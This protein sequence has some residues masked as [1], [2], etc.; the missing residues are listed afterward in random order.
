M[1]KKKYGSLAL[2][3]AV[4]VGAASFK[5]ASPI[6]SK[7][8]ASLD[9][10]IVLKQGNNIS[11]YAGYQRYEGYTFNFDNALTIEKST[12][13]IVL[14]FENNNN[15]QKTALAFY[16]NNVLNDGT[17]TEPSTTYLYN[18]NILTGTIEHKSYSVGYYSGNGV[19]QK[20][21]RVV[22]PVSNFSKITTDE[23]TATSFTIAIRLK[24]IDT[25]FSNPDI[26]LRSIYLIDNYTKN[27]ELKVQNLKKVY[28]PSSSNFEAFDSGNTGITAN[29]IT[30]SYSEESFVDVQVNTAHGDIVYNNVLPG[31]ELVI[32]AKPEDGYVLNKLFVNNE[33]VAVNKYG[34]YLIKSAP[35]TVN[36]F[37]SFTKADTFSVDEGAMYSLYNHWDGTVYSDFNAI[38]ITTNV[39]TD[40]LPNEY[41]YVGLTMSDLNKSVSSSDF[42]AV[43]VATNDTISRDFYLSINNKMPKRFYY[44]IDRLGNVSTNQMA[45]G[46]LRVEGTTRFNNSTFNVSY[47]LEGFEGYIVVPLGNYDDLSEINSISFYTGTK[48][49]ANARFNVGNIY[50][51]SSFE[52]SCPQDFKDEDIIWEPGVN[53]YSNYVDGENDYT[54][55][56]TRVSFLKA[57]EM[58]FNRREME[59]DDMDSNYDEYYMT[60]PQNMIGEDGYVDLEKINVKG[61]VFSVENHNDEQIQFAIRIASSE[62]TRLIYGDDGVWQTSIAN[63]YSNKIIYDNG[64]VRQRAPAFFPYDESGN[65]KGRV[66]IPLDNS[67]FISGG[68][69]KQFP[70]KIQPV[71]RIIMKG[72]SKNGYDAKI[73]NFKFITNEDDYAVNII[74]LFPTN[75]KITAYVGDMQIG[76][77]K[78]N[79]VLNNT[80]ITFTVEANRGYSGG[81]VSAVENGNEFILEPDNNGIYHHIVHDDVVIFY[82]PLPNV[83]NIIYDLQGG[84]NDS[85]NPTEFYF[86]DPDITLKNPTKS[87]YT[88]DHWEDEEGNEITSINCM[89]AGDVTVKAVWKNTTAIFVG[90]GA[91][92]AAIIAI[93]IV[94][95]IILIKKKGK[96]K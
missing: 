93:G 15:E 5:V 27:G 86:G 38:N 89:T 60:L 33:E 30:A 59:N 81:V 25:S 29:C 13:A 32:K 10:K 16:L 61:L 21:N 43:Q 46:A 66:Y 88:F 17:S 45:N 6:I 39:N 79:K 68:N 52:K 42:V 22:I 92:V 75:G 41:H 76:G 78:Y 71:L 84:I 62:S 7:A 54:S 4:F 64:V 53:N 8:E 65:F 28:T 70:T 74:S 94:V 23:I 24:G 82:D 9:K 83:Y 14:D 19:I 96:N 12:S 77:D 11:T 3:A 69:N 40:E 49:K 95:T 48:T 47:N 58:L 35:E 2:L 55:S 72:I 34:N 50:V 56:L 1:G 18:D 37:A 31:D 85:S 67:A 57:K 26:I 51:L 44:V 80:E 91:G 63:G 20:Y 87:G 73:S 90:I 36:V